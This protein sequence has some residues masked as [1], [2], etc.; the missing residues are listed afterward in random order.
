MF[1]Q[2]FDCLLGQIE[3]HVGKHHGGDRGE[4]R[5]ER[6]AASARQRIV[7]VRVA[8]T[9]ALTGRSAADRP[10]ML[11]GVMRSYGDVVEVR[12]DQVAGR[13]VPAH[14]VWRGAVWRVTEVVSHWVETGTWWERPAVARLLGTSADEQS[15]AG[16]GVQL[17]TSELMAERDLWRVEAR[18]GRRFSSGV[19][20]LS[21][22]WTDGVWRLERA[23]D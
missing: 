2:M 22:D 13:E 7:A 3:E 11:G 21:F 12:R 10:T 6:F 16:T 1:E 8:S 9:P 20:E 15:S 18:R 17:A 14:F 23:V 5:A 4:R 19:F